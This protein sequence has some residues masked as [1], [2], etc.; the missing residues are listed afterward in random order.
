M[1]PLELPR[2]IDEPPLMLFWQLDDFCVF[3]LALAI[4]IVFDA[5]G[6]GAL[7]GIGVVYAYSRYRDGRPDLYALHGLYWAGFTPNVGKSFTNPF[8]RRYRP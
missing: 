6:W 3:C 7:A 8:V 4:G 1:A 5:P 2:T